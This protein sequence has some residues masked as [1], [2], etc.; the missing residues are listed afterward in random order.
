MWRRKAIR[1]LEDLM[2]E[3]HQSMVWP[4]AYNGRVVMG[5][6][7]AEKWMN[8]DPLLPGVTPPPTG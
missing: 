4:A 2:G 3:D 8:Y 6:K 1:S 7:Y 5:G